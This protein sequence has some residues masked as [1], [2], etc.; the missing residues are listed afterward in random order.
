VLFT[1]T[2]EALAEVDSS[3]TGIFLKEILAGERA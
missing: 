3:H 1:G 2:P